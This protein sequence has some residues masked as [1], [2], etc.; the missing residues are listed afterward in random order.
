MQISFDSCRIVSLLPPFYHSVWYEGCNSYLQ[1]MV[2]RPMSPAHHTKEKAQ[3]IMQISFD[4]CR[5]VSL[6]PP[7]YHSVW[8]EGCNSYLQNMVL[9]PMSPAHHTKEKRK[10]IQST[11]I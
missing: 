9:R 10:C 11:R 6:L 1:N 2:L 3:D 7:F 8:Y 4:S 5:I